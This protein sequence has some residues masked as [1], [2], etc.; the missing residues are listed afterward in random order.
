[1]NQEETPS[2]QQTLSVL[3]RE[4]ATLA[5]MWPEAPWGVTVNYIALGEI[6]GLQRS[7]VGRRHQ[8]GFLEEV[9]GAVEIGHA[10]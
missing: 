6:P 4:C 5:G 7:S 10:L 1:M 9:V 8:E 3:L 2:W